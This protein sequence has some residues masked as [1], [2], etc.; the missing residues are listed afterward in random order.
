MKNNKIIFTTILIVILGINIINF[1]TYKKDT[2]MVIR[3]KEENYN[4]CLK[5][6]HLFCDNIIKEREEYENCKGKKSETCKNIVRNY[7]EIKSNEETFQEIISTSTMI[8]SPIIMFLVI[9]Y[10]T[11]VSTYNFKSLTIKN[12][13]NRISYKKYIQKIYNYN[14]LGILLPIIFNTFIII[15]V[16]LVT[17]S[18]DL[19]FILNKR[20][21]KLYILNPI[22]QSLF[23][24]NLSFVLSLR[25]K[26]VLSSFV[27]TSIVYIIITF[28]VE[29]F[30][31]IFKSLNIKEIVMLD[32][33]NYT[34]LDNKTILVMLITNLLL[35]I[36]SLS[37]IYLVFKN[38]ERC[39]TL[40]EGENV[41]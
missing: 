5:R 18:F 36:C 38:K 19:S 14:L 29:S 40:M 3:N 2:S 28:I 35:V 32:I 17:K 11:E 4:L 8:I 21:L 13:L 31:E 33:L 16:I 39:I 37:T 6:N 26:N 15:S 7:N 9:L 22:L 30:H 20:F 41:W 10:C 23:L 12:Y 24:A 27:K 25:S 1:L 34:G